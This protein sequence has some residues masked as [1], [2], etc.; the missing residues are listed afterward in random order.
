MIRACARRLARARFPDVSATTSSSSSTVPF[1]SSSASTRAWTLHGARASTSTE[2]DAADARDAY[3]QSL[4]RRAAAARK[5]GNKRG[6]ASSERVAATMRADGTAPKFYEAVNVAPAEDGTWRVTLDD[7]VLRTPKRN[8]YGFATKSLAVAVAMEWEA[9]TDCV[10]PFTMPLTGLSATAIDHMG[11]AE[12]RNLHVETLLKH[13]RTDVVRVRSSD[14][15]VRAKQEAT[16]DPIVRWATK[17]FGPVEVSDS[18]FGPETSEKTLEVLRKRLHSMCPWE[19]TCAFALSAAT[20]SLL[21]G[22]KTLRGGLTVEEAIAA[23]RVEEEAQ[24]EEWGLVEGGHDL[25]Q[26]DIK[27]KVSAPVML[28]KLRREGASKT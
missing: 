14:D 2:G 18:I 22:L 28:M 12:T 24:I 19:L 10:A 9:Q 25:D 21:I 16:H 17:E 7:R 3:S 6:E 13:F 27:V 1:A 8:E 11:D 26:L 15:D 5:V 20:K 23:A 4:E